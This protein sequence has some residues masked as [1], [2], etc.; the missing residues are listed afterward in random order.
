MPRPLACRFLFCLLPWLTLVL[1]ATAQPVEIRDVRIGFPV[2]GGRDFHRSGCWVPVAVEFGAEPKKTLN[3]VPFSFQGRLIVD[4]PD[5]E[6][7]RTR[8]VVPVVN[9][10]R[11]DISAKKPF[12][13][14]TKMGGSSGEAQ[15]TF[16]ITQIAD[17][18][19]NV[20]KANKTLTFN[21]PEMRRD[22]VP[23]DPSNDVRGDQ[24]NILILGNAS[25]PS[26]AAN[27]EQESERKYQVTQQTDV[28]Y[29]PSQW[30]GYEGVD[31][32]IL[33]TGGDWNTSLAAAMSKD[34]GL[35][36]AL[37][38]WV[39]QGGHLVIAASSN[40]PQVQQ[41]PLAALFPADLLPQ[42]MQAKVEL[43]DLASW[44]NAKKERG[45][46]QPFTTDL[47]TLKLKPPAQALVSQGSPVIAH[48]SFGLG[49]VTLLAFDIDSGSFLEWKNNTDFWSVLLS[50]SQ[51]PQGSGSSAG[52]AWDADSDPG[53]KAAGQFAHSLEQ[54]GEMPVVS[55]FLVALFILGYIILIGP[56]DYFF[57]KK[58]AKR[59]EWTWIT[60]PALVLIVSVGAYLAAYY[61]KGDE[62]R[63]NKVDL[64][65]V[66]LVH[67]RAVGNSWVTVFSPNLQKYDLQLM[68]EGVGAIEGKPCLSW[69]GRPGD[70]P[71][72]FDRQQ[73]A[74]LFRRDYAYGADAENLLGVPIQVWGMKTFM[75]RWQT[76]FSPGQIVE[77]KITEEQ[78]VLT[79]EIKSR[80]TVPLKD[81]RLIYQGHFWEL[82]NLEPGGTL[83][84]TDSGRA[85]D[86]ERNR[87]E[88]FRALQPHEVSVRGKVLA[89][90][91]V[92]LGELIHP[93][94]KDHDRD[95]AS[96]L[97]RPPS[98]MDYLNQNWRVRKRHDL[99]EA[100][101]LA[102]V[103]NQHGNAAELNTNVKFGSKLTTFTPELRGT[104]R[105]ATYLRVFVP[106][107]EAK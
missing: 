41:S 85:F 3:D 65:D 51:R 37:L 72:G 47:V 96:D 9:V 11:Q 21:Y 74:G 81:C 25:G 6:G 39:A 92:P 88:A 17:A 73:S 52:Y 83:K 36:V 68:P 20:A 105:Q 58:V 35:R 7:A 84:I 42:Q 30:F 106:V 15:I 38:Q 31:V 1:P 75:C 100:I 70:G 27:S 56:V 12:L 89:D 13:A 99:K 101:F 98:Y 64:I 5:G 2:G 50:L 14:Y 79:G 4:T 76:T 48:G 78:A 62:M 77:A 97:N 69:L 49:R 26:L 45:N 91:S 18:N 24:R 95:R 102:T 55:F 63:L 94:L 43:T 8:Y 23:R 104:L 46:I 66:D 29:L 59:L 33:G 22:L 82:G 103:D 57:L 71:R 86:Q 16:E 87:G 93:R 60:F 53:M 80:L 107:G 28:R 32:I 44:L 61:I 54:F 19:G 67:R 34:E 90:Y 40:A 10:S